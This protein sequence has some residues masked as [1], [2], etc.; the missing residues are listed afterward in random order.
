[1]MLSR[2]LALLSL[3]VSTLAYDSVS[4][5]QQ[6]NANFQSYKNSQQGSSSSSSYNSG[7]YNNVEFYGSGGNNGYQGYG[8]NQGYGNVDANAYAGGGGYSGSNHNAQ[9]GGTGLDNYFNSI[10]QVSVVPCQDSVVLITELAAKC[11][12]PY[13]FYYGSG[14]NRNS[15][16]CDYGDKAT[17]IGTVKLAESLQ[18]GDR[19]YITIAIFDG[20]DNLLV[21]TQPVDFCDNLVGKD[22]VTTGSY[23]FSTR[24]KL[25]TPTEGQ[26]KGFYPVVRVAFSTEQDYGYNLGAINMYCARLGQSSQAIAEWG[27]DRSPKSRIKMFIESNGMLMV[28]LIGVVAFGAFVYI[29]SNEAPLDSS[30]ML[31]AEATVSKK[32]QLLVMT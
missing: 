1:M 8:G 22:C 16:T 18:Y 5:F 28:A 20:N 13:T 21:S 17:L 23:K 24:V 19:I 27:M 32:E 3:T 26:Q 30:R 10:G 7:G 12:S 15:P 14:G 4:N 25:E 6:Y 29:K 2:A 31:E 9:W 11:D